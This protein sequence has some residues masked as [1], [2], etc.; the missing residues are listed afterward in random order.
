MPLVVVRV[1]ERDTDAE[2]GTHGGEVRGGV[3]GGYVGVLR[4]GVSA[5]RVARVAGRGARN[6]GA[7]A[8]R[9][10]GKSFGHNVA[11]ISHCVFSLL[12][13]LFILPWASL[14]SP[15]GAREMLCRRIVQ[16]FF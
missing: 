5:V 3:Y 12:S 7:S 9:G 14:Y 2:R 16:P 4:A 15:F 1:G 13:L 8:M 11:A 10:G 6:V